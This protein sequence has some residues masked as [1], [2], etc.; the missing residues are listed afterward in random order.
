M[1]KYKYIFVSG[2]VLSGLGKGVTAASIGLLLKSYGYKVALIK[3]DPYVNIDAGTIRPQEHGETFVTEDGVETDQDLGHYERFLNE[4]LSRA[5]C[6]T[7]GQVYQ[8]VIRKERNFEYD[9]ED[10]EV[11]PHVPEEMIRRFKLAGDASKA[12]V[13]IIEIGG[14]VGEYQNILFLEANRIMKMRDKEQVLHIHVAYLP[15]PPSIGEMKSKPVQ[16]SVRLLNQTGIQ[17]DFLVGRATKMLDQRRK[18]RLSLFCNIALDNIISNPYVPSPYQVP[19]V[20]KEQGFDRK[21]LAKLHLK[22]K[23]T[24]LFYQW[25][26]MLDQI[27]Q[28]RKKV[29]IAVA[30]KYQTVGNYVLP[31][32]YVC[33]IESLKHAGWQLGFEPEIVWFNTEA[34][35][36]D[37]ELLK[38]LN[39]VDGV[40]VPQGWGS[41]GV[42]GKIQVVKY[43]R[44]NKI[45][46]LGLCFGMQIAVIEISRHLLGLKDANSTEVNPKTPHP[47]IHIMPHQ[48]E[49]LN[50]KQYGGT[51]RL[52]AWPCQINSQSH[53]Y[54]F[55]QRPEA[56][57]LI[58][59]KQPLIVSERHRHRYEFNLKYK[60][61]LEKAGLIIAGT[62]PDKK[63]V[64]A[65]ELPKTIHPF[66]VGVQFH[67]EF[68]S[69]PLNPHPIF[70]EFISACTQG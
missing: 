66:F 49:Y 22:P 15:T 10:V 52:G 5:H 4:N 16:I 51:M 17:P 41:R 33:V 32:A 53:L 63:L 30:G 23:K 7:T 13:I 38:K 31:D 8:E 50:K 67:P 29:K 69:R 60:Q 42:E 54:H 3:C 64:E 37:P 28:A 65:I 47:V 58:V 39:G 25:Q 27:R 40:V 46:Y 9:G 19:L 55:Y 35:E 62:S 45:P 57:F 24:N 2:G 61:Q 1:K 48:K 68:K 20:F 12:D 43:A 70:L 26:K 6:V 59:K 34:V 14:T 21:I 36:K 11:V 44:E 18:N 56:Q